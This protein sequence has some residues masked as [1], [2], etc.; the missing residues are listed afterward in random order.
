MTEATGD[1]QATA[2]TQPTGV[3]PATAEIDTGAFIHNIRTVQDCLPPECEIMAVVKADAYGHG[4]VALADIALASGATWLGVARCLEGAA[5]RQHGI[6]A[7]ILVLG[8]TWPEE[9]ETLVDNR[10]TPTIGN[11]DD[12]SRLNQ[13]AARHGLTYPM[14]LKVDTSMSRYGLLPRDCPDFLG[15][16]GE[17]PHLHLQG[18]MTHLATADAP[19]DG[20]RTRRHLQDFHGVLQAAA[21]GGVKPR[22]VHAA[23]SAGIFR[24]PESH[25]NLV[26]PG[27]SLYGSH[28]FPSHRACALRPVMKWTTRVVRVQSVPAGT[29]VSYGHTFVT[30][31]TSR[32]GTLPVGYADGLDRGLSNLGEVLVRGRRAPLV[33]RVC[34]GLCVID[35]TDVPQAQ[36]GDEAVLIGDQGEDLLSVDDMAARCGRIPYELLCGIGQQVPRRHLRAEA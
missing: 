6:Q 11:C 20:G 33:G 29:G 35:L 22:Y 5:L 31:R 13:Q 28:P 19:D 14:H 7:P 36:V 15:R 25:G 32:L 18:V 12:A 1:L 30:Q 26:R 10:L 3:P 34:M 2:S 24:Y 27:I 8:P 9:V 21:D 16:L 4:A 17:W 23:G